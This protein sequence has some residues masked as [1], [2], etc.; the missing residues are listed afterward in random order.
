MADARSILQQCSSLVTLKLV[1]TKLGYDGI[2]FIFNALRFN[3]TLK[4]LTVHDDNQLPRRRWNSFIS[5]R[6]FPLPEKTTCTDFLLALN[7]ILKHNTTLKEIDIQSGL[8]VPALVHAS[9]G[10]SQSWNTV[11]L[12]KSIWEYSEW[13]GYGRLQQF[14]LGKVA[15]GRCPSLRRSFSSSD[16]T[17]S[18]TVLLWDRESVVNKINYAELFL[19]KREEGKKLCFHPSFTSP[20]T[21][22][23]PSFSCLDLRLLKFFDTS[24]IRKHVT[25][26]SHTTFVNTC[27]KHSF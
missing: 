1:R 18:C 20:D 3:T 12:K 25:Y 16:I 15:N 5:I 8:F 21:A 7:S 2:L 14:N 17:K 22:V 10:E 27:K 9:A 26:T 11:G 19:N 4:S 6:R 13:T 23:I 24:K